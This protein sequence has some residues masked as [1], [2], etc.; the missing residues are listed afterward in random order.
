MAATARLQVDRLSRRFNDALEDAKKRGCVDQLNSFIDACKQSHAMMGYTI[1]RLHRE[2][3]SGTEIFEN[4][5]QLEALRVR[6]ER[7]TGPDWEILRNQVEAELLGGKPPAEEAIHYGALTI[8]KTATNSYGECAVVLREDMIAHR[9]SC[10]EEN[11]GI[12]WET[13]K[14]IPPGKRS[15][16]A[17]RYMLCIAKLGGKITDKSV[18]TDFP[19][20]LL[21]SG[22]SKRDDSFIEAQIF[23]PITARTVEMV[24]VSA[25]KLRCKRTYWTAIRSKLENSGVKVIET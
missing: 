18:N 23:G 9:T 8:D 25:R 11:S 12:Y 10:F 1:E 2:V 14:N 4:Y 19:P 3:S 6:S 20:L 16:W 24:S 17:T 22:K 5:Y 15:D 7:R 13:H 21:N